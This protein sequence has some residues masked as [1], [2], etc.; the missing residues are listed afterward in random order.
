LT[1]LQRICEE[2]RPATADWVRSTFSTVE[3]ADRSQW[4]QNL[5]T[6][7]RTEQSQ[8]SGLP[9]P[10]LTPDILSHRLQQLP[11]QQD[12]PLISVSA[13]RIGTHSAYATLSIIHPNPDADIAYIDVPL[14]ISASA[15]FE[16]TLEPKWN[17]KGAWRQ[18]LPDGFPANEPDTLLVRRF[19]WRKDDSSSGQFSYAFT[20]RLYVRWLSTLPASLDVNLTLIDKKT[21]TVVV[22]Q[23]NLLWSNLTLTPPDI[24]VDWPSVGSPD[25]ITQHPVGPQLAIA[26]LARSLRRDASVA[27]TAP[28]RF[29]KTTLARHL[30]EQLNDG[31][32]L[33]LPCITCTEHVVQGR[34]DYP[35]LWREVAQSLHDAI[36]C[37]ITVP[38]EQPLPD[39][40]AFDSVR[41]AAFKAGKRAV[42]VMLDEAQLFFGNDPRH[43]M[44]SRLK[45][46]L[47]QSW[48]VR[49]KRSMVPV[50][51]C[52]IG[53][54]SLLDRAGADLLGLL[55]TR[56]YDELN[57][58]QLRPLISNRVPNLQ[59][60]M[61]LRSELAR[62]SGNLHTVRVLL[63]RLATRAT[64][65]RRCWATTSDLA[66]VRSDVERDL[67]T[68]REITLITYI[69]DPLNES[70]DVNVWRPMAALSAAAALAE[71]PESLVITERRTW[72][73]QRLTE[74]AGRLTGDVGT[75]QVIDEPLADG[76]LEVLKDRHLITSELRLESP[77]LQAWLKGLAMRGPHD[78]TLGEALQRASRR[79]IK[80]P[81]GTVLEGATRHDTRLHVRADGCIVYRTALLIDT[82]AHEQFQACRL[83]HDVL[84]TLIQTSHDPAASTFIKVIDLGRSQDDPE[85]VVQ[86]YYWS[87]GEDLRQMEGLL[88]SETV[89]ELGQRL[90]AGLALLHRAHGVHGSIVPRHVLLN[91]HG[92]VRTDLNPVLLDFGF[93]RIDLRQPDP[94]DD[95]YLAPEL[96]TPTHVPTK[97]GDVYAMSVTLA[98][99]LRDDARRQAVLDILAQGHCSDLEVR[100]TAEQ[101]ATD[102][103]ETARDFALSD[104][105]SDLKQLLRQKFGTPVPE[106]QAVFEKHWPALVSL[107]QGEYRIDAAHRAVAG[108]S[109][110]LAEARRF[111]V[112][113]HLDV[114]EHPGLRMLL[115]LRHQQAHATTRL[116]SFSRAELTRYQ[117]ITPAERHALIRSGVEE[118]GRR[119]HIP[120]LIGFVEQLLR[121]PPN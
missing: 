58:G 50:L 118:I 10:L 2:L 14:I 73:I 70:D 76:L 60:S 46:R 20:A 75:R 95:A 110:E 91:Q 112:G 47:E 17:L 94:E 101:M 93:S 36:G 35:G 83:T 74:W 80:V 23:T 15:P 107:Y 78:D 67:N 63:E 53:L 37:D 103:G 69:R 43:S 72:V 9:L 61:A 96:R 77:L 16:Q 13:D 120:S 29:G 79:V 88:S 86:M 85:Q 119:C 54:P 39:A 33:A 92:D 114:N 38:S 44:G 7:L 40:A 19:Q 31:D 1:V 84:R 121:I 25:F 90:F 111:D 5:R 89:I 6:V 62:T 30:A 11:A 115:T 64:T 68:G 65:E 97:A 117:A 42:V 56:Q 24:S 99:M 28:R 21:E 45:A 82:S 32:M 106:L 27:V 102:L 98:A 49:N 104:H 22:P 71:A 34:F 55:T 105:R 100:K 41:A 66:A 81:S 109:H 48:S 59:T 18:A 113:R 26:D 8:P 108:F 87:S 51:F 3:G 52:F 116:N 57:E 12:G 4:L